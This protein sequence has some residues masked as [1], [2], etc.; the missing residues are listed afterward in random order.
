ML[1]DILDGDW[2]CLDQVETP[3]HDPLWEEATLVRTLLELA[4]RLDGQPHIQNGN[5]A[6]WQNLPGGSA[7]RSRTSPGRHTGW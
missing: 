4:L 5:H 7:R 1:E 2:D 3:I 6:S